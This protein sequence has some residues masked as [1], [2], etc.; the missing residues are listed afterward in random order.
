MKA[1]CLGNHG[2]NP[3]SPKRELAALKLVKTPDHSSKKIRYLTAEK[4]TEMRDK[5]I[6]AFQDIID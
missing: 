4:P 2:A 3:L 5:S 1:L 6:K